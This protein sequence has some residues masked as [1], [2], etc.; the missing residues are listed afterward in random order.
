MVTNLFVSCERY[1]PDV[2]QSIFDVPLDS[3]DSELWYKDLMAVNTRNILGLNSK[4]CLI[5]PNHSSL[6]YFINEETSEELGYQGNVGEGPEDMQPWPIYVGKSEDN[7]TIFLF[8]FN[9]RKLK[10]FYILETVEGIPKL[11]MSY[12]KSLNNP[13]IGR[14]SSSFMAMCK[15][16]SGYFVGINY[17]ST[18]DNFLTLLDKDLNYVREFG[19]HPLSGLPSDGKLKK[20]QS[21]DGS[22]YSHGNSVYYAAH[23]FSYMAR[24]DIKEDGNVEHNWSNVYGNISYDIDN[25]DKIMFRCESN[26]NGFSDLTIGKDLIFATYS[27]IPTEQMY[28]KRSVNAIGARTLVIFDHKGKVLGRFKL[29]SCSFS[30]GLS[31]DEEYVY[32]MNID[33]EVQ[34]ERIKVSDIMSKIE[35]RI[36]LKQ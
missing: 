26:L 28:N 27:G 29:K 9:A 36:Q 1:E 19:T 20:L 22:L 30:V 34:L 18:S 25:S 33:P 4:L 16:S 10:A 32:V 24:Y 7:D 3:V 17:L 6:T 2:T 12:S 15:L 31:E 23:K 5:A 11:K 13:K 14:Y 35:E 21:F 8:D